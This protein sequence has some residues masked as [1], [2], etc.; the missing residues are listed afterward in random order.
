MHGTCSLSSGAATGNVDGFLVA[1]HEAFS[2]RGYAAVQKELSEVSDVVT[3]HCFDQFCLRCLLAL[4]NE[5]AKQGQVALLIQFG[6]ARGRV[7]NSRDQDTLE[8]TNTAA[9]TA[10]K[11]I[12]EHQDVKL[13][14]R[15]LEAWGCDISRLSAEARNMFADIVLREA[16]EGS[17]ATAATVLGLIPSLLDGTRTRQVLERVDDG[18]RDDMAEKLS[19]SLG[20]DFQVALVQRRHDVGRLRAAAKAVHAFGLAAEFPDVDF[21]WRSQALESAA[22]GGRREPVVGLALGEPLLRRRC[23]EVLHEM[24]EVVLAVDLSEAWSIPVSARATEEVVEARKLLAATHF[25]MPDVVRVCLVDAEASLPQLRS[26]LMQA[27]AV[28]F[29]V[30]WCPVEG[31]PPSLLQISTAEVAFVVDLLALGGSDALAEVLDGVFLD[32][33]ITKV[34][35]EGTTDLS[36]IAKRYSKLQ[37]SPQATPLVNLGQA[38]SDRSSGPSNKKARD[39]VSLSKLVNT[40]LGRPLDKSLQMS[41]WS[42]RPLSHG[43]LQYAA[44]D[45]WVTL[46]LHSE[47]ADGT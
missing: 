32:P 42:R 12:A 2:A 36:R 30:E 40:Y 11:L 14:A 47:F 38:A 10:Q 46:R 6:P 43:Q 25:N 39:S 44:L 28:G 31:S 4:A 5:P 45:A 34:S 35:F 20:R 41:D 37:R 1:L 19:Q 15:V 24:G 29:D 8:N 7:Q 21:A 9:A 18:T 23:V 17:V 27:A 33:S 3:P 13:A 26:S 22:K 16:N